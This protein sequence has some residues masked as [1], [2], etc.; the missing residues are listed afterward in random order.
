MD[1]FL[2]KDLTME[3][4]NER[5]SNSELYARI[6]AL[7]L[8]ASERETALSALRDGTI[9]ADSILWVI[10]GIKRLPASATLKR[11]ACAKQGHNPATKWHRNLGS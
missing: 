3:K 7:P 10:N 11:A 8:T 4:F 9:I 5:S 1:A 2:R 6:K